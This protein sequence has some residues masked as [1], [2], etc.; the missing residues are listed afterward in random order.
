MLTDHPL[1]K[2]GGGRGG[3]MPGKFSWALCH[4]SCN[5]HT[6]FKTD[7]CDFRCP[8]F[9]TLDLNH[10]SKREMITKKKTMNSRPFL[11][12]EK[13]QTQMA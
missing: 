13:L 5:P 2:G 9:C 6:L 10:S 1:T 11:A 12:S 3:E 8:A 4:A 7:I